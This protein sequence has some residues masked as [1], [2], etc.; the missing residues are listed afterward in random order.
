[1]I[2]QTLMDTASMDGERFL[3]AGDYDHH[4]TQNFSILPFYIFRSFES[5]KTAWNGILRYSSDQDDSADL[6]RPY[7]EVQFD[8]I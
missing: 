1:M 3:N 6:V 5:I 7:Q 2:Q 8:N 4:L